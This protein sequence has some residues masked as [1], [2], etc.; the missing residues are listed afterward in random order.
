MAASSPGKQAVMLHRFLLVAVTAALLALPA[1][2][3]GQAANTKGATPA[4]GLDALFDRADEANRR[5]D[6]DAVFALLAE[7]I[8]R[9]PD[10][11]PQGIS[12]EYIAS[13]LQHLPIGS[14]GRHRLLSALHAAGYQ[15]PHDLDTSEL[16]YQLA[17]DLLHRGEADA[18]RDVL[19]RVVHPHV[20]L[21]ILVDRRFDAVVSATDPRNDLARAVTRRVAD[22]RSRT[23]AAPR[24]GMLMHE[25]LEAMMMAGQQ[26]DV[27]RIVAGIEARAA[28][29][30]P[31]FEDD[32]D[33]LAWILDAGAR[34][35]LRLGRDDEALAL[36]R[37]AGEA[38]ELGVENV[39]QRLNL[40]SV[41]ASLERAD[42]AAAVVDAVPLENLAPYGHMVR[43]AVQWEVARLRGDGE[44]MRRAGDHLRD[45]RDDAPGLHFDW[46]MESGA[47]DEAA[48]A[49][50]ARLEDPDTRRD[51]LLDAQ[52][53]RRAR[54]TPGTAR[55]SALFD[56]LL[57]RPDVRAAIERVGRVLDVPIHSHW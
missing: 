4:G 20:W 5:G 6:K 2:A 42:D 37:K 52:S 21:A 43:A 54:E 12:F 36:Y 49:F 45:H 47:Q 18:A 24:A 56:A 13:N 33:S 3:V 15:R 39:S 16:W 41:L 48:T 38:R 9:W 23:F 14:P 26:D 31:V 29:G 8:E 50:I 25:Q 7:G 19:E 28:G 46:L 55:H 17:L 34:A 51:A 27:A 1:A 32:G 40:A 53:L 11:A 35:L 10:E 57:A 44:A 22:L 30:T